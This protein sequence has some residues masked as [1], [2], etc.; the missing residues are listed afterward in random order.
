MG[1][2]KTQQRHFK[3][4]TQQVATHSKSPQVIIPNPKYPVFFPHPPPFTPPPHPGR[5]R[6][7]TRCAP[8]VLLR[9]PRAL[10][11]MPPRG[12]HQLRRRTLALC[13]G[14]RVAHGRLRAEAAEAR[15]PAARVACVG[16]SWHGAVGGCGRWCFVFLAP[17]GASRRPKGKRPVRLQVT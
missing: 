17:E 5:H 8:L 4:K 14:P 1:Y 9:P 12:S 16:G 15:R 10:H 2:M 13:G 3:K 6:K 11:P 7:A